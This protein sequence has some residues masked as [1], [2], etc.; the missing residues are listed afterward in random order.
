MALEQMHTQPIYFACINPMF[1]SGQLSSFYFLFFLLQISHLSFR[2]HFI[3]SIIPWNGM[4]LNCKVCLT[5]L[6]VVQSCW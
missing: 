3:C 5:V 1:T 2:E 6:K 4:N